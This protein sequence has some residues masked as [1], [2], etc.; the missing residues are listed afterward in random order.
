MTTSEKEDIVTFHPGERII[1]INPNAVRADSVVIIDAVKD[2]YSAWKRWA[3]S[4]QGIVFGEIVRTEGGVFLP[5]GF[6]TDVHVILQEGW[7]VQCPNE[8][9]TVEL[10]GN[11]HSSDNKEPFTT[12]PDGHKVLVNIKKRKD[13]VRNRVVRI[14]ALLFIMLCISVIGLWVYDDPTEFEPYATLFITLFT[15]VQFWNQGRR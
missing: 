9:Q 5:S 6:R 1:K 2:I 8:A 12:R 10:F 7:K 4:E 11:L 3:A 13:V 14:M 15:L